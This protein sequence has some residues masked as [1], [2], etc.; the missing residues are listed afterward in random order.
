MIISHSLTLS[1]LPPPP[2][3]RCLT[4][5]CNRG[6]LYFALDSFF[7]GVQP[8]WPCA[9]GLSP[10]TPCSV[11][12]RLDSPSFFSCCVPHGSSISYPPFS[13]LRFPASCRTFPTLQSSDLVPTFR[14]RT[15]VPTH[16]HFPPSLL[17]DVMGGSYAGILPIF[18]TLR[19]L[20][21]RSTTMARPCS[22]SCLPN[23]SARFSECLIEERISS[24]SYL[25]F[26]YPFPCS[27]TYSI[28]PFPLHFLPLPLR[29]PPLSPFPHASGTSCKL[30]PA[31]SFPPL[32]FSS[33]L[34]AV[35]RPFMYLA[36]SVDIVLSLV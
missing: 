22:S 8:P 30:R 29:F 33:L 17:L 23:A 24:V 25:R 1:P 12:L 20:E 6:S 16:H 14:T 10:F 11:L 9:T 5:E 31:G 2:R 21:S 15:V 28:T 13:F 26:A 19:A 35:R 7:L 27:G 32:L 3:D 4:S 34:S 36:P 18:L